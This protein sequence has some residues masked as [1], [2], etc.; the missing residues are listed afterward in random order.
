MR[1]PRPPAVAS[2]R[3]VNGNADAA[4]LFSSELSEKPV[5]QLG[6]ET[7]TG[8]RKI[9]VLQ[10]WKYD[11]THNPKT[12]NITR[13]ASSYFLYKAGGRKSL[14]DVD[15]RENHSWKTRGSAEKVIR[16]GQVKSR[17]R[18]GCVS[19]MQTVQQ[20]ENL[21]SSQHVWSCR[22]CRRCCSLD[23]YHFICDM[24]FR[25]VKDQRI[26]LIVTDA[27]AFA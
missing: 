24:A 16:V 1:R 12:L 26:S 5:C 23:L 27:S 17:E 10:P 4:Y 6:G 14:H 13:S 15:N 11:F 21:I 9:T 2:R 20:Q 19:V 7:D 8:R 18:Q 3:F 22:S 25:P